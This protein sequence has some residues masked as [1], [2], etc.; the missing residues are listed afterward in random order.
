[1]PSNVASDTSRDGT[2]KEWTVVR[3]SSSRAAGESG[4]VVFDEDGRGG[5]GREGSQCP[6]G[7]SDHADRARRG[8]SSVDYGGHVHEFRTDDE[9]LHPRRVPGCHGCREGGITR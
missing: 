4:A 6:L 5:F 9:D 7:G 2:L 1:M 8:A 3:S